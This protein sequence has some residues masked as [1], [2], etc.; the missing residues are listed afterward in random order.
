MPQRATALTFQV[1]QRT[2]VARWLFTVPGLLYAVEPETM[3]WRR[4]R[5][6]PTVT[7]LAR[8]EFVLESDPAIRARLGPKA[9][10]ARRRDGQVVH[11]AAETLAVAKALMTHRLN[12]ERAR[13]RIVLAVAAKVLGIVGTEDSD[14]EPG[15]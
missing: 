9:S 7:E 8:I 13:V 11:F 10:P 4:K 12:P 14:E 2:C 1:P 15:S 3:P 5:T 6:C